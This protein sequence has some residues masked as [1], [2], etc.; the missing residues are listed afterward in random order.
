MKFR[1]W[2]KIYRHEYKDVEAESREETLDHH[3]DPHDDFTITDDGF[4]ETYWLEPRI[5]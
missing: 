1:L 5:P 3:T 2:R 4:I